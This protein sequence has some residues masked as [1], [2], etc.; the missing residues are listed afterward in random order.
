MLELLALLLPI[1]AASGW[2]LAHRQYLSRPARQ[3]SSRYR[4]LNYFLNERADKAINIVQELLEHHP[5]AIE[6]QI[7]LGI[8]FRKQGYVEKAIALHEKLLETPNLAEN[9]RNDAYF[10]L[11]MDYMKSGLLDRAE[12]IFKTLTAT[13]HR[14]QALHQL[15]QIYQQEKDWSAA[16]NCALEIK[17]LSGA[18]PR[19]E[20]ESQFL[21][22]LAE[23]AC[24]RG[25]TPLARDY[26]ARALK[27]EPDSI[28][29]VLVWAKLDISEGYH[30]RVL[31]VLV[32][33]SMEQCRY[34]PVLLPLIQTCYEQLNNRAGYRLYLQEVHERCGLLE[35]AILLSEQLTRYEGKQAALEYLLD[36]VKKQPSSRGVSAVLDLLDES[37]SAVKLEVMMELAAI[38]RKRYQGEVRYVCEQCGFE[39]TILHW[40]C[41]SCRY[42]STIKPGPDTGTTTPV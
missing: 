32:E 33:T 41:P 21:A 6:T 11:G 23:E 25:D 24:A 30:A 2:Y 1:A 9:Q 39:G 7:A 37:D 10:E 14:N 20:S 36:S 27:S 4:D 19:G 13:T 18:T 3:P 38:L 22:E 35:A 26:I 29:A 42:W 28:R 12:T 8:L 17:R 5:D 16:M 15:L 40:R 34:F 31:P